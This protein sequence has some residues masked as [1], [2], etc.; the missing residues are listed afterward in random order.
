MKEKEKKNK[1]I[2]TFLKGGF[3]S[4]DFK[5]PLNDGLIIPEG[6]IDKYDHLYHLLTLG[7]LTDEEIS[8]IES[9]IK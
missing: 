6:M 9:E 5:I 7:N 4:E 3:V 8:Y 1:K 2:P